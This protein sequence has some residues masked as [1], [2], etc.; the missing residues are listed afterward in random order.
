MKQY[1]GLVVFS[2]AF[3]AIHATDCVNKADGNYE[4]GCRSYT[5]CSS[6]APKII[7]CDKGMVY[8]NKTGNCDDPANVTPPCGVMKDCSNQ[9][10]GK[11]ADTEE[12][13]RSYYSC[14]KGQFL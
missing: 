11:Y 8:N 10:D 1:I 9:K 13:C 12:H 6:G 2:L 4:I 14:Y 3:V 5:Q 7:D